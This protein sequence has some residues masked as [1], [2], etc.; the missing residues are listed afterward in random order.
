MER[1]CKICGA[2]ESDEIDFHK[3]HVKSRASGGSN[4]KDNLIDICSDCHHD[5]HYPEKTNGEEI[6]DLEED[7]K[8]AID[9]DVFS[10]G[11]GI[12]PKKILHD[13]KL[14]TFSKMLYCDISS[15]C[16]G[17]GYCWASNK[18]F[19]KVFSVSERTVSRAI[20]EIAPFIIIKNRLGPNRTIWVHKLNITAPTSSELKKTKKKSDKKPEKKVAIKF[21]EEDRQMAELLLQKI[22]YNFPSFE[23]KKVN[24][25][26]WAEDMRKLREIDKASLQQI[27]FMINWLQGGEIIVDGKPPRKFEPHEFWSKNI[28]SAKKLRKQ[29]FDNLVPQLQDN[30]LKKIKKST[31]T[32]L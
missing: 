12:V 21:T 20:L 27:H 1:I 30:L 23:N 18:Y 19:A 31:V 14:T 26:E 16:A 15:L 3:H 6:D 2:H 22:I 29:W 13:K 8:H 24:I 25:S 11:W 7:Y 17:R 5:I 28:L 32:Q 4:S 10:D 9:N